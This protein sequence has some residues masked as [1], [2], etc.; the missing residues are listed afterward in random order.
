MLEVFQPLIKASLDNEPKTW[1]YHWALPPWEE[2]K[3][4]IKGL[5]LLYL[6][7]A[8]NSRFDD[9]HSLEQVHMTSKI[10]KA[11]IR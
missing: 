7:D 2:D 5:E 10:F 3:C 4:L 6:L 9:K 8:S 1:T 11:Y